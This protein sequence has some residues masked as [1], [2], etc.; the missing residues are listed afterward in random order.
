MAVLKQGFAVYHAEARSLA[1]DARGRSVALGL[2]ASVAVAY[3]ER[4]RRLRFVP[5]GTP[6]G[7]L[8]CRGDPAPET[9]PAPERTTG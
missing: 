8:Q 9:R 6:Q 2:S 7:F 1:E 3:T 5:V 4:R